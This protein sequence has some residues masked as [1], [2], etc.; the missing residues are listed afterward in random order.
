MVRDQ[1][2]RRHRGLIAAATALLLGSVTPSV[3]TAEEAG[4]PL[5]PVVLVGTPGLTWTDVSAGNTPALWSLLTT[6]AIG[7]L[8]ARSVR[9]S[10]CPVDGWLAVSAGRRAA[11]APVGADPALCRGPEEPVDGALA[12][13][14]TYREEAADSGYDAELGLLGEALSDERIRTTA[15]GPGAAIAL[16]DRDGRLQNYELRPADPDELATLVADE[17]GEALVLV[18][19]AGGL[20]DPADVPAD[21]PAAAG[22]SRSEQ[23]AELDRRVEAV[24][25]GVGEQATVVVAALADGGAT[26]RMGLIAARGPGLD[27]YAEA[28]LTSASTRQ[29][30]ITQTL[31][32]APTILRLLRINPPASM[33]GSPL[34]AIGGDSAAADRRRTVLGVSAASDAVQPVVPW[35][36]NLLVALN[37]VLYAATGLAWSGRRQDPER[38]DTFFRRVRTPCI[39]LASVPVATFLADLLPW[40]RWGGAVTLAA[41]TLAAAAGIT[42][43]AL[44]LRWPCRELAPLT[45]VGGLTAVV[46]AVDVITGT[47]LSI[48]APLGLQPLVAGRFYGFG[49]VQYALFATGCLLV[50]VALAHSAARNGRR[51]A[52]VSAVAAVGGCAV[53]L[54]GAPGLGTDLGGPLSITPAFFLLALLAA[55]AR[56]SA[57][58]LA[59]AG[60]GSLGIVGGLA[61]AD[62]LRPAEQRT[63][64]GRF[65]QSLVDGEAGAIVSRKLAQNLAILVGSP[66]TLLA[67]GAILLTLLVLVAPRRWGGPAPVFDRAPLLRAG[68]LSLWTMLAIGAAIN[69]SGT[70]VPAMGAALAMPLFI[71]AM[72]TPDRDR[73]LR[74]ARQ[75]VP[76]AGGSQVQ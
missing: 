15:I 23:A 63:H 74:P 8:T 45:F 12:R 51:L 41:V 58:G 69:D 62:W 37:L 61:V 65:I 26:P 20:R 76:A 60:V 43:F 59:A 33:V 56:V 22:P 5:G 28:L 48:A 19:D 75:R 53:I 72:G 13:W 71:A 57:G 49:N 31:D 38:V 14:P 3:A 42:A 10:A 30:A 32:V 73:G 35:V 55:G 70:A 21:D 16:A 2:G 1:P 7:T 36:F 54:D 64:F 6:G 29:P 46:L 25:A 68:V 9:A 47:R 67:L 39:A 50:A 27:G 18:V 24:L 17:L 40:W 44:A 52:A 4:P 66:L 34:D 11:D